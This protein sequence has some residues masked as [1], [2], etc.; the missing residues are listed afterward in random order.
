MIFIGK[1]GAVDTKKSDIGLFFYLMEWLA[2]GPN[3]FFFSNLK[4]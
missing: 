4:T 3:N 2:S 1:M